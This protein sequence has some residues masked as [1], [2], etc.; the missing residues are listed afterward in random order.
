MPI[1]RSYTNGFEVVDYTT[2]LT[3]VPK[4]W[5]LLNDVGLF[6]AE[7]LTTATVT[8]DAIEG[9]IGLVKDQYRGAK[10][11][12]MQDD[13]RK[14]HSY[15]VPHFPAVDRLTAQDIMGK[16]AYGSADMQDTQA[17]AIARKL[18]RIQRAFDDTLETARFRTLGSLQAYAPNG[19]V[20]ADFASDFGITQKVV[21][22]AFSSATTDVMAKFEEA[23]AHIQD[24][25][26]GTGANGIVCYAGANWFAALIAHAKVQTAYQYYAATDGQSILRNRAGNDPMSFYR[27]FTY[28]NVRVIEVRGNAPDGSPYVNA[29]KAIFI[30]VG[31]EGVF[32][33]YFAPSGKL[34]LVGSIAEPRYLW[35]YADPRGEGIDIEAEMNM[36][37][38][39]RQPALVVSATKS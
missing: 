25:L 16:R 6:G 36:L 37:N 26:K 24:N 30:P 32:E 5:T 35:T 22:F 2:E 8:F 17:A 21:D 13:L 23:V 33:T 1:T 29:D 7:Y 39:I 9:V 27:E 31:T 28:G 4:K 3:L 34:D 10:P 19:T 12:P 14:I 15:Y 18:A 11:Q 38:V 20:V